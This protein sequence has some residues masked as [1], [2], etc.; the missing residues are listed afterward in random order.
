MELKRGGKPIFDSITVVTDRRNL[1][2]Q[3]R[4][5]IKHFA[6]VSSVIGAV[7]RGSGQLR[8]FIEQGKKIIISAVQK[9]PYI[10]EEIGNTHRGN[11]FAVLIDEAHS[12]QG[13]RTTA[14]LP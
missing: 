7:T 11:T 14:S 2:K 9:F 13:G 6:Q 3:I 12:G 4:D 5:N 1:D 8:S 10:L